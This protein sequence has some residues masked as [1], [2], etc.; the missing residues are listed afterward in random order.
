ML[1]AVTIM[2]I[3]TAV[4]ATLFV[5]V[6]KMVGLSQWSAET[7][8]QVRAT[9]G[10]LAQDLLS[11]D[12]KGYFVMLNRDY[13]WDPN[14]TTV[15]PATARGPVLYPND[16]QTVNR[17]IWSDRIAFI[18]NGPFNT[19]QNYQISGAPVIGTTAR[20]YY[21]HSL[22]TH[23]LADSV[24]TSFM[25][26][27]MTATWNP[28]VPQGTANGPFQMTAPGWTGSMADR[29]A[30]TWNLLRQA[31]LHVPDVNADY[32]GSA[33]QGLNRDID[34]RAALDN[35]FLYLN[36]GSNLYTLDD[37]TRALDT[38]LA[39]AGK[40]WAT[41]V[42]PPRADAGAGLT[43]GKTLMPRSRL[44]LPSAARVRFQVRLSDGTIVPQ[45]D[46]TTDDPKLRG[47]LSGVSTSASVTGWSPN[48]SIPMA[49]LP[50][51][52]WDFNAVDPKQAVS[53]VHPSAAEVPLKQF[54]YI[55]TPTRANLL[56]APAA[57]EP[58][59]YPVALRVRIEVYDPEK[60]TP[61]PIAVD[62]WLP[63]RWRSQ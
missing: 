33:Y 9:V 25:P 12:D 32:S 8:T 27:T 60:R 34:W 41:L 61:D 11:F 63:I 53:S 49:P 26:P 46:D 13:G 17:R 54:A 44:L 52:V 51:G 29:P 59:L 14:Q 48:Y 18:A 30:V 23:E 2:V 10:T 5:Q 55:W 7:R 45:T 24:W 42:L 58:P 36:N 62:E 35:E 47:G 3:V 40:D 28:F 21:G 31:V 39:A 56:P 1:V 50:G 43:T 15:L 20:V 19:L 4:V 38:W 6:R 57:G 37:L 16:A 22:W